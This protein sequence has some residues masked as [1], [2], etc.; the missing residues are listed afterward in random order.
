MICRNPILRAGSAHS[1]LQISD[2]EIGKNGV[3][4]WIN[5]L[6]DIAENDKPAF[7]IHTG[8]I[9]YEPGLKKHIEDMNTEN[10]GV[11]VRYIIGNHDCVDGK[12]GEELSKA[13]TDRYGIP[14]RLANV[15]YVVTPFRTGADRKS[16]YNKMTA[17]AGLKMIWQIQIRI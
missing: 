6:K 16:A 3:G 11:P 14:L 2:T 4:E 12:Y 10:M 13:F 8:D 9:C 17:G 5:Y 15:H 7:L 1:F